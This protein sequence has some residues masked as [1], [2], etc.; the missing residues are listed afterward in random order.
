MDRKT[1]ILQA[2]KEKKS[3]TQIAKLLK[4]TRQRAHQLAKGFGIVAEEQEQERKRIYEICKGNHIP[5]TVC[6]RCGMEIK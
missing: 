4:V 1:S 2:R 6:Q 3:Y 5:Q